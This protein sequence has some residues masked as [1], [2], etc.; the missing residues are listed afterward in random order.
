MKKILLIIILV[1][2][3][4]ALTVYA[5]EPEIIKKPI[6]SVKELIGT[7]KYKV[8]PIF[9]EMPKNEFFNVDSKKKFVESMRNFDAG[10]NQINWN[11]ITPLEFLESLKQEKALEIVEGEEFSA[12]DYILEIWNYP[13]EDWIKKEDIYELIKLID[14]QETTKSIYVPLSSCLGGQT[15]IGHE[16]M[17]LIEGY[18]QKVYPP[19]MSSSC[20]FKP[21]VEEYREWYEEE[22]LKL[23]N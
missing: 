23:N 7:S 1:L 14:S 6:L 9:L 17:F 19:E 21:N 4:S 18:K 22:F 10:E 13:T 3:L 5:F 2:F 12:R 20:Y 16:V 8:E 11:E 15:T